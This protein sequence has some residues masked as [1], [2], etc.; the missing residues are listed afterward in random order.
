MQNRDPERPPAILCV[1]RLH[2][3]A[4]SQAIFIFFLFLILIFYFLFYFLPGRGAGR[5]SLLWHLTD[6]PRTTYTH[7]TVGNPEDI[8]LGKKGFEDNAENAPREKTIAKPLFTKFFLFKFTLF[9]KV[10]EV[11]QEVNSNSRKK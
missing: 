2:F 1:V 6:V 7:D 9:W 10:S 3:R 8:A 4:P 11:A 5:R